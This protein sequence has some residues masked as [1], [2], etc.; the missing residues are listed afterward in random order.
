MVVTDAQM[1]CIQPTM[2]MPEST[3]LSR[4]GNPDQSVLV[5]YRIN[6]GFMLDV[7]SHFPIVCC[8][9]HVKSNTSEGNMCHQRS[10]GHP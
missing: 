7:Q 8:A 2:Q 10:Y 9:A 5:E 3:L 4:M 6:I 1:H